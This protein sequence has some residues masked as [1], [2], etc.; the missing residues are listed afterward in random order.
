MGIYVPGP[1]N[2][3]GSGRAN[4]NYRPDGA[5]VLH[6]DGFKGFLIFLVAAGII[7]PLFHRR[8]SAR[9]SASCSSASRSGRSGSARSARQF[10]FLSYVTF[11]D[12]ARAEPLAE[13]GIIFLLFLLGLELS[14]QRLWQLRRYVLGV[15]LVQVVASAL[16][17]RR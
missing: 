9:C 3:L 1:V 4:P 14:L 6:A 11:D 10:P 16:A 7:V 12:P 13:L 17:D 2:G 5:C 8:A 15:G